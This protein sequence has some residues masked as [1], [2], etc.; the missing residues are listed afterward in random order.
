MGLTAQS[1]WIG[2][3]KDDISLGEPSIDGIVVALVGNPNTG[4]STVFNSLTGLKQH[5]GNWPGK[6]VTRAQGTY[7]HMG[8]TFSLVDL[9]GSYSLLSNSVEEEIARDFICFAKPK[10][11]VIVTDATCLERNLNLV[12]QVLEITDRVVVC[13]NLIDEAERKKI[14]IDL[15]KLS[16]ILGVPVV[17]TNARDKKGL[18]R[19]KD[20]IYK[21]SCG[22]IKTSPLKVKYD[23]TIEKAANLIEKRLS[24]L[25]KGDLDSRWMALRLIE[26]D[27]NTRDTILSN[28]NTPY[29]KEDKLDVVLKEAESIPESKYVDTDK[30]RDAIVTSIVLTAEEISKATVSF[31][32]TQYNELDRKIDDILTSKL[33]GIPIMLAMLGVIFWLTISGANY[34]SAMLAKGLFYI[35]DILTD[36]SF[37]LGVPEWIHGVLI[38]GVYRTVAWV[39]SVML[40]PMAIFFPLFTLL[41]DLGYLPRVAFNLDNFFKKAH[42]HGKQA[43]TM[44]MGFGCN[45]AGVVACRIIDSPRERL[46]ATITNNFV[47]C[48]GRFPTLIA[49]STIFI[50]GSFAAFQTLIATFTLM[51]S[52][53]FAVIITLVVSRILSCTILKGLPSTFTLELPP[54]RKPQIGRVLIRSLLDRTLFVLARAVAVAAPAG[55]II[56]LMANTNIR[57]MSILDW[58]AKILEPIGGLMGMDGYILLAFILGLPANEIVIPIIVMSYMASGSLTEME[59]LESLREL[60]L[61]NGWTWVTAACTMLFSLNH[62]PCG[63]TLFTIYKETQSIR[64]TVT[65]FLIPTITGM[66]L[67]IFFRLL[68]SLFGV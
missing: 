57:D 65:S 3:L 19:L 16:D 5:T 51:A 67:C 47:P 29:L 38:L 4:K 59:S 68:V 50:A 11:C 36:L 66:F 23:E 42:T 30:I 12:L 13:V 18:D 49:L 31:E 8:Q 55:L 33:F 20:E 25:L 21:V 52:I 64:W 14:H 39:I 43:L 6:T 28:M 48:N 7:K 37:S 58:S 10:C 45:A 34:P 63:T 32:N 53:V 44:C 24:P 54:Y 35:E 1:T 2:A 22:K 46:I 62:F 41:E 9:P 40:P 61:A 26:R 60:L 56:W 27:D 15:K 17:G